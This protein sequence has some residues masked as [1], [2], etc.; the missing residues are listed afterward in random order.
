MDENSILRRP[1]RT[2]SMTR[3]GGRSRST[4][5]RRDG[6]G[7]RPRDT[8]GSPEDDGNESLMVLM[9]RQRGSTRRDGDDEDEDEDIEP[10]TDG[11]RGLDITNNPD[12][13][14]ITTHRSSFSNKQGRASEQV[15]SDNESEGSDVQRPHP[16]RHDGRE[17]PPTSDHRVPV[18]APAP[19]IR[20]GTAAT[21]THFNLLCTRKHIRAG[22]QLQIPQSPTYHVDGSHTA[23]NGVYA[24]MQ[25][26]YSLPFSC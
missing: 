17:D 26:F 8:D 10:E 4:L 15:T 21:R 14:D 25:V 19:S 1:A 16:A 5:K 24:V 3:K 11:L 9:S 2:K 20:H 7:S 22:D 23:L 12:I 13:L 6:E 18:F